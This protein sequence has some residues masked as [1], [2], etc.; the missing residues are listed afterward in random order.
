VPE[1]GTNWALTRRVGHRKVFQL[2]VRGGDHGTERAAG[3]STSGS[4]RSPYDDDA[5]RRISVILVVFV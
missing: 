1:I 4:V 2:F 3:R 5:W